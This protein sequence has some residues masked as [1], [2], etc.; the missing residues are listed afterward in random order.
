MMRC[1]RRNV[2]SEVIT[3]QSRHYNPRRVAT[4][5]GAG[6]SATRDCATGYVTHHV[7]RQHGAVQHQGV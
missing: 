6:R 5:C 1:A 2:H 7:A 4:L 3:T